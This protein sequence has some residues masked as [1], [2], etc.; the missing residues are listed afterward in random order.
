[1][2]RVAQVLIVSLSLLSAAPVRAQRATANAITTADFS[3]L[4]GRWEG[5]LTGSPGALVEVM[6]SKPNARSIVGVMRL[7]KN[8][9]VLVVELISLVDTP[10]GVEMRFRHFSAQ[11]DAYEAQFKQAMRLTSHE[12]ERDVF[13]NTVPYDK[14]LMS[15]QPRTTVIMRQGADGFIGRSNIIGSDGAPAV[16][17]VTYTRAR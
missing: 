9:T 2:T 17:E 13:A 6:Y 14:A 3:W 10:A 1:M 16:V 15:T 8:D 4:V 11:L 12:T 5:R 7:V